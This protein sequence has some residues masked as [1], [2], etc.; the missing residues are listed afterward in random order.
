MAASNNAMEIG[1]L[2]SME[3]QEPLKWQQWLQSDAGRA[4]LPLKGSDERY[5]S[6]MTVALCTLR[7]LP[8]EENKTMAFSMPILFLL[9]TD[10]LLCGFYTVNE[11]PNATDLT[12][13]PNPSMENVKQGHINIPVNTAPPAALL[14]KVPVQKSMPS[15]MPTKAASPPKA[16][17][18]PPP[19][20]SESF[21]AS[22]P[23]KAPE[24]KPILNITPKNIPEVKPIVQEIKKEPVKVT[25][26]ES[27]ELDQKFKQAIKE[28]ILAFEKEMFIMKQ[29]ALNLKVDIGTEEEKTALKVDC[30]EMEKFCKDL[31]EITSSQNQEIHD[32]QG[33]TVE[34]FEWAEEAKSRD[35]RNKDPRYQRLLKARA[36]DP[37]SQKRLS[38]V[39]SKFMYLEQQMDEVNTKLDL[40]WEA[41]LEK[42]K[43]IFFIIVHDKTYHIINIHM[44]YFVVVV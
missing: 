29:K 17:V 19:S 18:V 5:P 40:E 11:K 38:S 24:P 2:G 20:F 41:H 34:T 23:I 10:G 21:V 30:N 43:V 31:V 28:E 32:L 36:L 15:M 16:A 26:S 1:V 35:V 42:C 13:A 44:N 37:L 3:G 4:E 9:S 6:G 14:P 22:T 27:A 12:K 8:L 25:K 33:K 7:K 39:Q